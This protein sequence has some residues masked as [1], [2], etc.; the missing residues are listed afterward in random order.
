ME[1]TKSTQNL[2]FLY[3]RIFQDLL[4]GVRQTIIYYIIIEILIK[5]LSTDR[6]IQNARLFASSDCMFDIPYPVPTPNS[7]M[8]RRYS[9]TSDVRFTISVIQP[10]N[11]P[12]KIRERFC[13]CHR[14]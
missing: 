14:L 10:V 11:I 2:G 12:E 13:V 9:N 1:K 6:K 3:C 4:L 8:G 7:I 5:I